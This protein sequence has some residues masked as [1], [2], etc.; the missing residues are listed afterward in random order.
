MADCHMPPAAYLR[1]RFDYDQ[2]NGA[3]RWRERIGNRV[4]GKL[5]G[6]PD[7][8]GYLRV[9]L[10]GHR[11]QA[12]RIAW[13]IMRGQLPTGLIDHRNG[14]R[15][16]NSWGNL[17]EASHQQ[18]QWNKPPRR[19]ELPVG[20]YYRA[21]RPKPFVAQIVLGS[22]AT[23]AEA[24]AARAEAAHRLQGSFFWESSGPP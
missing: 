23:I 16:D 2:A 9:T 21:N 22:F 15:G 11:Y 7:K 14:N 12:H 17:R 8:D 3:L 5:A 6:A 19:K 10:D 24:T 13:V 20:I 18:N 1:E 4:A